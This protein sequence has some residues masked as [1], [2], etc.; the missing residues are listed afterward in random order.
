MSEAERVAREIVEFYYFGGIDDLNAN[1]PTATVIR[2]D[3]EIWTKRIQAALDAARLE[4]AKWWADHDI[5]DYD[6]QS[7]WDILAAERIA[8]LFAKCGGKVG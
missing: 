7:Q 5:E 4:E 1:G 2:S 3:M 8:E 6:T